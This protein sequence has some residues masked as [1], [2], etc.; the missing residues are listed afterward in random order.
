MTHPYD[1]NDVAR[2][3]RGEKSDPVI[4]N[5]FDRPE[6]STDFPPS[7]PRWVN[8]LLVSAYLIVLACLV[9]IVVQV[10]QKL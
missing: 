8:W 2:I 4:Q 1:L 6:A 10:V 7:P 9:Y 3:R 5:P